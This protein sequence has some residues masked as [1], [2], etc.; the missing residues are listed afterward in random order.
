MIVKMVVR[1]GNITIEKL[2]KGYFFLLSDEEAGEMLNDW[3]LTDE[4]FNDLFKAIGKMYM[5]QSGIDLQ[6]G[7][8]KKKLAKAEK[9]LGNLTLKVPRI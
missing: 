9:E 2:E 8:L 6:I 3:T 4:N 1:V 7:K 5:M